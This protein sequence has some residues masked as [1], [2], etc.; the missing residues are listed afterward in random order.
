MSCSNAIFALRQVVEYFNDRNS[1]VYVASLDASKAFD[2]VNHFKLFT[3]LIKTGVPK[4]FVNIIINW[5]SKLSVSVKW[6]GQCSSYPLYV[7]SGVRQGGIL[8]PVLFN[9]Y[10]NCMISNLRKYDYGCHVKNL[11]LGC[12]MYA[13]DLL[14]ISASVLDLQR[15]LD[16][17]AHTG[18]MLGINFNAKKSMCLIIGSMKCAEPEPMYINKCNI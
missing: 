6:N 15:M 18:N 3:T 16:L 5:Y 1:N 11:F 12:I 2:R 14:L 17:C 8:S 7:Q 9:M 4:C 13:D 10:I